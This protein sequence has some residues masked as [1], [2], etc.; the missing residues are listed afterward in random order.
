MCLTFMDIVQH[1]YGAGAPIPY[2]VA[3]LYLLVT[4]PGA[5]VKLQA[6]NVEN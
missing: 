2:V 4:V 1:T 6:G 5:V 3:A